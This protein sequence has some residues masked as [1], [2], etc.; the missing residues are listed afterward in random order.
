MSDFLAVTIGLVIGTLASIPAALMIAMFGRREP[1]RRVR[2]LGAG[3]QQ[4]H[5]PHI[6][7]DPPGREITVLDVAGLELTPDDSVPCTLRASTAM[8][9]K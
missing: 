1:N 7:I 4:P 8:V 6:V 2:D 3:W 5:Q 9:S